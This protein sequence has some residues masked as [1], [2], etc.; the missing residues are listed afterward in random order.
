MVLYDGK[1]YHHCQRGLVDE[2]G[3]FFLMLESNSTKYLRFSSQSEAVTALLEE[4][5]RLNERCAYLAEKLERST[6][7]RDRTL[8]L[9]YQMTGYGYDGAC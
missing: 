4:N 2:N 9:G 5:E 7:R 1:N 8:A 6:R 3:A